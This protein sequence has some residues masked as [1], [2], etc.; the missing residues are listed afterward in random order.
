LIIEGRILS[1]INNTPQSSKRHTEGMSVI[2]KSEKFCGTIG[3]IISTGIM[4][5]NKDMFKFKSS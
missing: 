1:F 2:R 4:N 5:I 3:N